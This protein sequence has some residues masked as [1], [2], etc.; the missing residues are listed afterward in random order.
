MRGLVLVLFLLVATRAT[1]QSPNYY[2]FEVLPPSPVAGQP[3]QLRVTLS[4]LSCLLLPEAVIVTPLAGNVVQ[5]ELH[6]DD[7]CFPHPDQERSYSVPPLAAGQYTFRLASCL[8][9]VPPLPNEQCYTARER[10]VTVVAAGNIEPS[11]IPSLSVWSLSLLA[12]VAALLGFAA[13]RRGR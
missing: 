12:A 10:A 2:G 1:A 13:M 3:F 7:V 9:A 4:A 11:G 6:M 8:H 5:Y